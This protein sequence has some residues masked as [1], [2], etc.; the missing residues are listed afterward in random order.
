MKKFLFLFLSLFLINFTFFNIS[1][2]Q[3]GG[4]Y[5]LAKTMAKGNLPKAFGGESDLVARVGGI[6]GVALS[7]IGL[8]FLILIVYSGILWMTASGNDQQIE[9]S[10]KIMIWA[11][12]GV[13]SVFASFAAV[14][15]IGEQS[16]KS[17]F[18]SEDNSTATTS[19]ETE[20][21][22]EEEFL[23]D[24]EREYLEMC[25]AGDFV[26][27]EQNYD[28]AYNSGAMWD[29][30]MAPGGMLDDEGSWVGGYSRDLCMCFLDKG[31][32]LECAILSCVE[33]DGLPRNYCECI[34]GGDGV[35]CP[36]IE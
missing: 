34:Y 29:D 21:E 30:G 2:A 15:F 18:T 32:D 17:V 12:I 14:Q 9:K 5:G 35:D 36:I 8:L 19:L 4:D 13:I 28:P 11:V 31:D 24:F 22:Q 27:P 20:S 10:K 25:M 7:F 6:T 33:E 3:Q 26:A 23:Y 1:N 16:T